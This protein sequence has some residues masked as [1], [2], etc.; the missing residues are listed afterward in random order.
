MSDE[1]KDAGRK[2]DFLAYT[3]KDSPN[4]NAYW[5]KV[6]AAWEHKDGQGMEIQFDSLPLDGRVTL[7]ELREE[8]MEGYREERQAEEP[9]QARTRNR[10]RSR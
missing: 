6:G 5:N 7:R 2:P 4:G 1:S 9:A 10:D 8:R 3:V